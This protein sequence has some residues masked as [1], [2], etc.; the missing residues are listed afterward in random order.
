MSTGTIKLVGG[1]PTINGRPIELRK[2]GL[3]YLL[4]DLSDSMNF[5]VGPKAAIAQLTG[6]S[7]RSPD[8]GYVLIIDPEQASKYRTKLQVA[9]AGVQG[10]VDR[11]IGT[12][13]VG[14]VL[15]G[16]TAELYRTATYDGIALEDA[17]SGID[18]HP[19]R[20]GSTN[21][22]DAL[23]LLVVDKKSVETIVV[24][25]DGK[26]DNSAMALANG[27]LLKDAGAEIL[28]IGTEDADWTFLSSLRSRASL[29][30]RTSDEG[31]E[32][33]I[34]NASRLLKA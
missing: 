14:I 8:G 26:P 1:K 15:F 18:K 20:G 13:M 12:K 3:V 23:Y 25:T 24:V 10:F 2:K 28:V 19:L 27:K 7:V 16:S 30:I 31:L 34:T 22:A 4:I 21:L 11:I 17:I 9:V 33:A 6:R 5:V 32:Q 29:S